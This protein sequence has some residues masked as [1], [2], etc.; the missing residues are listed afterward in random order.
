M[1]L[2]LR[3]FVFVFVQ[4]LIISAAANVFGFPRIFSNNPAYTGT[5]FTATYGSNTNNDR[6]NF[7]GI[8]KMINQADSNTITNDEYNRFANTGEQSTLTI[9]KI[10]IL[11]FCRRTGFGGRNFLNWITNRTESGVGSNDIRLKDF[12]EEV[13]KRSGSPQGG[14][15]STTLRSM[16][17]VGT[18]E[19][20]IAGTTGMQRFT[21]W[22]GLPIVS[23]SENQQISLTDNEIF[24]AH[25]IEIDARIADYQSRFWQTFDQKHLAPIYGKGYIIYL[26]YDATTR[27]FNQYITRDNGLTENDFKIFPLPTDDKTK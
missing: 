4:V 25:Q 5:Y 12:G 20:P 8:A 14:G 27:R 24:A 17:A 11:S 13:C 23:L 21:I 18:N 3:F 7:V 19:V 9:P 16:A 6:I 1:K 22:F 10:R 26:D 15:I 2:S